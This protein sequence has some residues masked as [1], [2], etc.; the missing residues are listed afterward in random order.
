MVRSEA[1]PVQPLWREHKHSAGTC[2]TQLTSPRGEKS[3]HV[4]AGSNSYRC[5]SSTRCEQQVGLFFVRGTAALQP[6]VFSW[7]DDTTSQPHPC[8][9]PALLPCTWRQLL[10]PHR[11]RTKRKN[12]MYL[13]LCQSFISKIKRR[14]IIIVK[15][16]ISN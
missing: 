5:C 2:P 15:K 11:S 9:S 10:G 3:C 8:T 1:S 14:K 7:G 4:V 6:P 13:S 12:F 16:N